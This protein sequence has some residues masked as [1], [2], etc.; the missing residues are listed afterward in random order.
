MK[1]I[2]LPGWA[3]NKNILSSLI[4]DNQIELVDYNFYSE[5]DF[6]SINQVASLISGEEYGIICYSMGSL[7]ALELSQIKKPKLIISMGGFCHFPGYDQNSKRRRLI[8]MQMLKGLKRDPAKTISDFNLKAGLTSLPQEYL[9]V[10]NLSKGLELLKDGDMSQALKS[11]LDIISICAKEDEIVPDYISK[12]LLQGPGK[13]KAVF[14]SGNHG[15]VQN[16]ENIQEIIKQ[17]L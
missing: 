9:N 13:R 5:K 6:P 3:T 4:P 16:Q 15:F 17:E 14:V 8:I 11:E 2:G 7:L 1:W 12:Q 10:N